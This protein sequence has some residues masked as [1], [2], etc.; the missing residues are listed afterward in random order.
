MAVPTNADPAVF[1][2]ASSIIEELRKDIRDNTTKLMIGATRVTSNYEKSYKIKALTREQARYVANASDY[3]LDSIIEHIS[4]IND[5]LDGIRS[6]AEAV[7]SEIYLGATK[8]SKFQSRPDSAEDVIKV[9]NALKNSFA[10]LK[11]F[12]GV[13]QIERTTVP[14]IPAQ[15]PAPIRVGIV[16]NHLDLTIS[17]TVTGAISPGSIE[18]LRAA[19]Q[20]LL[21][22]TLDQIGSS[23]NIDPRLS[24]NLS[25]L[26]NYLSSNMT[27]MPIEALGL[28]YQF[29]KR[30]FESTKET[31]PEPLAE[32]IDQ[33]LVTVNVI[34]NQYEEWRLYISAE[35]ALTLS[36]ASMQ[37]VVG[38][39]HD[40]EEF[41]E[42]NVALVEPKLVNRLR[43]ITDA[44][45]QGLVNLESAAVP[46]IESLGNIF[47]ELSRFVISQ[48]P[49][50][51][52]GITTSGAVILFLGFAIKSIETFTPTLSGFPPLSYLIDVQKFAHKQFSLIKD[53]LPGAF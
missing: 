11:Y 17:Q 31:I 53:S 26:N 30:S 29:A 16:N 23:S 13:L 52:D 28:N 9:V 39:S 46:L 41:F 45:S 15:Q 35:T 43:E 5:A 20:E 21:S 47:S 1:A 12:H 40:V 14:I 33:V 51:L 4:Y 38:I 25:G 36:S 42:N 27:E 19:T 24:P 7:L 50:A 32:Q 3:E 10:Q 22:R 18:K 37:A 2:S 48:S 8:S 6:T 44:Y 34:L 49:V